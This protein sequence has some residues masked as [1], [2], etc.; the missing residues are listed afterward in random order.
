M[1]HGGVRPAFVFAL[2][3]MVALGGCSAPP[4][5]SVSAT[6]TVTVDGDPLSGTPLSGAPL[7]GAVVTL[8]PM[9]DTTGPNASAP[10]FDGTFEIPVT[11][12]L[13]GGTYRVRIAMIPA[14]LLDG[15]P[16]QQA[17]SLPPPGT[18]IDPAFDAESDLSC[19]LI[20]DQTNKLTFEVKFLK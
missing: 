8:E 19:Q 20:P 9:R 11:A 4:Q 3:L 12:G 1:Q 13:H 15:L 7:S 6:G 5:P 2:T 10:V 16:D 18:V 14:E 17:K